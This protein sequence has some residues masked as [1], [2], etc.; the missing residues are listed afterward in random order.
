M[1]TKFRFAM[2]KWIANR[3]SPFK[4]RRGLAGPKPQGSLL[5]PHMYAIARCALTVNRNRRQLRVSVVVDLLISRA[6]EIERL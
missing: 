4:G 3:S 5:G 2:P 1:T 6:Q